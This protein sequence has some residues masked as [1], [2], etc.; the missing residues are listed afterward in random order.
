[1]PDHLV[2]SDQMNL[3]RVGERVITDVKNLLINGSGNQTHSNVTGLNHLATALSYNY[4]NA[5]GPFRPR[6][7][8]AIAQQTGGGNCDQTG[9]ISYAYCRDLLDNL[10]ES[11]WAYVPGHTFALIGLTGTNTDEWIAVD[12]WVEHAVPTLYK[13]HFSHG[14][15]LQ[16]YSK[17]TGTGKNAYTSTKVLN[18]IQTIIQATLPA[19]IFLNSTVIYNQ[20]SHGTPWKNGIS[21]KYIEQIVLD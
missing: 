17:K 16:F 6:R 18:Q 7:I 12:P 14:N 11:A 9:A 1:M 13:H 20:Y 2:T 19:Q 15:N 5:F 8:I 10:H 4:G 3:L 21:Y